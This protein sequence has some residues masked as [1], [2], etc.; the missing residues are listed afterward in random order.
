M[1]ESPSVEFHPP[2]LGCQ[3]PVRVHASLNPLRLLKT[4]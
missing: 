3:L 4:P 2:N 1:G